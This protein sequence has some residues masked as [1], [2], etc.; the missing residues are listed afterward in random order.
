MIRWIVLF[1][2][3]GLQPQILSRL[4]TRIGRPYNWKYPTY[5]YILH[6]I[7]LHYIALHYITLYY[8]T[9]HYIHTYIYIFQHELTVIILHFG[10]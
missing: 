6:Y 2:L 8:I 1:K 4:T 7:T 9:L 5:I 3:A 10:S